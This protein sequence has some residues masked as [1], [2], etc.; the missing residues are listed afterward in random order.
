MLASICLPLIYVNSVK[1]LPFLIAQ[2]ETISIYSCFSLIVALGSA[3]SCFQILYVM[4]FEMLFPLDPHTVGKRIFIIL[5][6]VI[7][8]P[9]ISMGLINTMNDIPVKRCF[10]F[11]TLLFSQCVQRKK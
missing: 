8:L 11:Y 9:N 10:I 6:S 2:L 3:I 1:P 7:W 4:K 5:V